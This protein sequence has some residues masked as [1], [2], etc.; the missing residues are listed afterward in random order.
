MFAGRREHGVDFCDGRFR[1]GV[2]GRRGLVVGE[3]RLHLLLLQLMVLDQVADT[4]SVRGR[5]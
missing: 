2:R 4:R 3:R 1:F 5:T